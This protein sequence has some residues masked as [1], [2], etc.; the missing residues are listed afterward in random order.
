[1]AKRQRSSEV[2]DA[3][4]SLTG[5]SIISVPALVRIPLSNELRLSIE[6]IFKCNLC[7]SNFSSRGNQPLMLHC[8]HSLCASCVKKICVEHH[9]T[10]KSIK[11]PYCRF[12]TV[13]PKISKVCKNYFVSDVLESLSSPVLNI[14]EQEKHCSNRDI[15]NSNRS[16]QSKTIS[17][18]NKTGSNWQFVGQLNAKRARHGHGKC[19]WS[20]GTTYAGEWKDGLMDG[21][22]VLQFHTGDMYIGSMHINASHG[23]GVLFQSDGTISSGI[24]KD[25]RFLG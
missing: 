12:S 5:L 18:S 24:W 11:C 7:G 19:S 1:M 9:D 23:V 4:D 14:C 17:G 20:D 15:T 6:S 21:N 10:C 22:G 13:V 16:I 3:S 2:S 25:G 8:G